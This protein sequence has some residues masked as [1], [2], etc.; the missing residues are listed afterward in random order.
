MFVKENGVTAGG[1]RAAAAALF[2]VFCDRTPIT[3]K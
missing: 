1:Y 2:E 3:R